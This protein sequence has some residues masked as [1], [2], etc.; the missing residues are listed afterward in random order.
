[1][2]KPVAGYD[3]DISKMDTLMFRHTF[4]SLSALLTLFIVMPG[5]GDSSQSTSESNESATEGISFSQVQF[6]CCSSAEATGLV[7]SVNQLNV[8]LAADDVA[9]SHQNLSKIA[10]AISAYAESPEPVAKI[11]ASL[12]AIPPNGTIAELRE[13]TG[14]LNNDTMAF[15]KA[16]QG[17]DNTYAMVY[18]PMF[19]A[20]WVQTGKTIAN[21]YH[22]AEMLTCGVFEKL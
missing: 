15:I 14:A 11:A 19:R 7:E 4:L 10:T 21:P 5:C 6:Q 17:G 22:G 1:V 16:N 12:E 2:S 13:K 20:R 9:T 8:S 18:C 3:R